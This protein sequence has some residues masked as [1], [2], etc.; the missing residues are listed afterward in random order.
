MIRLLVPGLLG[1]FPR[2]AEFS[3]RPRLPALELL[4]ARSDRR[5]GPTSYAEALFEHFGITGRQPLPTASV[6]HLA[7]SHGQAE[8]RY[9]LHA[10]PIHLRPD[11]DR[12]LA[13]D[14]D[15]EALAPGTAGP[16]VEAF[17][18]HFADSG[19]ELLAPHPTRWY[20]AL[21]SEPRV[22]CHPLADI[23]GRNIDPFL[24]NG[25]DG[26]QWRGLLNEVQMLF[27]SLPANHERE[28]RGLLPISGLWFSGGGY[29]PGEVAA[30]VAPAALRAIDGTRK[31]DC[32]L[33]AGLARLAPSG[34][35]EPLRIEH[36][37]GRAALDANPG[38]WAEALKA[39]DA[40]LPILMRAALRLDSCDG[41][42][43]HWSPGMRRRIWRRLRSVQPER[44]E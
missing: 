35:I 43:L 15:R 31:V 6:C 37:A 18:H 38:A 7:D 29:L 28:S 4:I 9:L 12:L 36:A 40:Q 44:A 23:L 14:F 34:A 25:A 19:M 26:M 27:H 33:A 21:T 17:N 1:P 24:P 5:P 32:P 22:R 8:S 10:D 3:E 39:L 16:F 13:F 11:Q 20:L 30:K 41:F 2:R 42:S